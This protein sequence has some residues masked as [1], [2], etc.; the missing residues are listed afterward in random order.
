M[1]VNSM[2]SLLMMVAKFTCPAGMDSRTTV[3][4]CPSLSENCGI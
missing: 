4:A 1:G 3:T 2:Y